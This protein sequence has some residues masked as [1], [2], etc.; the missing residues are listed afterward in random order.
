[1]RVRWNGRDAN[2]ELVPDGVY[3]PLVSL[4]RAG[5][6]IDL[7]NPIRVDTVKP[8]ITATHLRSNGRKL[9]ISYTFSEPGHGILIVNR[10]RAVFTYGTRRHGRLTW[11][12]RMNGRV[13]K[14]KR[15]QLL[16]V[17]Q[18]LAG[19]RSAPVQLP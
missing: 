19:N 16:L 12:G 14:P 18:D 8:T 9:K 10:H 3:L 6:T 11:Y 17:A 5:R 1:V 7:P 13:V 4:E 2:G 15:H